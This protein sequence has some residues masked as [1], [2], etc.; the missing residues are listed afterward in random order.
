MKGVKNKLLR[1]VAS[2][3]GLTNDEDYESEQL[4]Y[5]LKRFS[6]A[7]SHLEQA[8]DEETA[9]LRVFLMCR[10]GQ[11]EAIAESLVCR[12]SAHSRISIPAN[13][14]LVVPSVSGGAERAL[15]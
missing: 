9:R 5:L 8:L 12:T 2:E 10:L 3:A 4:E 6:K 13:I 11:R 1:D 14:L 15:Q 7:V